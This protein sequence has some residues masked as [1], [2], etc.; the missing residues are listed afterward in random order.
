MLQQCNRHAAAA[1]IND[2]T[3]RLYTRGAAIYNRFC[4]V[5]VGCQVRRNSTMSGYLSVRSQVRE[6]LRVP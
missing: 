3:R 2:A 1:F 6:Y 5:P 4:N